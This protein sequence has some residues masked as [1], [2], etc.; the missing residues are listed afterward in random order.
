MLIAI[1]AKRAAP[2][3][4]LN[5]ASLPAS[6]RRPAPIPQIVGKVTKLIACRLYITTVLRLLLI[7]L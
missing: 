5:S 4:A 6:P 3:P 1:I 2:H 7:L